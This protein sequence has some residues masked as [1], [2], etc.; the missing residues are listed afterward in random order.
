[1]AE[2]DDLMKPGTTIEQVDLTGARF[3]SV[4]LSNARFMAVDLT[5]AVLRGADLVDVRI[6]GEIENLRINGVDVAPLVE[7]ELDRQYPDRVK[8]RPTDVAGFR[9]AWDVI[10]RLWD[11]TV[12]RARS[13][14]PEQLH[15]SVDEEWSF[16]Q[17][18]RHLVFAT[19][20]WI[21]RAISETP[22]RITHSASLGTR[23]PPTYR[24]CP[25]TATRVHPSTRCW[26]CGGTGWRPCARCSTT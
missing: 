7:A 8:M 10:E 5:G 18:L 23:R 9:E 19:D 12:N 15:E 24:V 4:D 17:T 16:I 25:G 21:G 14:Q 6:D 11:G 26:R 3:R 1:M 22:G 20:S 13:L 2:P